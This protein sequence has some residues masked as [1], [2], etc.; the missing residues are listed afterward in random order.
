MMR[1]SEKM[2]PM[3]PSGCPPK[4]LAG[5]IEDEFLTLGIEIPLAKRRRV[6]RAEELAD[7]AHANLNAT[8]LSDA[9]HD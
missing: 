6:D 1:L 5:P 9:R 8:Q 7:L 3:A 4:K 2:P